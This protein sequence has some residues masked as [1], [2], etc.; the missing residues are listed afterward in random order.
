MLFNNK[1]GISPLVA[2]I[3]LIAFAVSIGALI[4][5][6]AS[7]ETNVTKAV[8]CSDVKI[9]LIKSCQND[10]SIILSLKNQG[11]ADINAITLRSLG[12]TRYDYLIPD[13]FLSNSQEK[14]LT[15]NKNDFDYSNFKII[16]LIIPD[17]DEL[18]CSSQSLNNNQLIQC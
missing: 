14:V 1:R 10:E 15:I 9:Y 2:T 12:G 4:M 18:M 7:S 8:S 6:W 16:P 11:Q 5:N 3:L 17:Q 13:S